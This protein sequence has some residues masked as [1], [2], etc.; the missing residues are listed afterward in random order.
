MRSIE[1]SYCV[2][3][4]PFANV[5]DTPDS[6]PWVM[7]AVAMVVAMAAVLLAAAATTR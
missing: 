4:P 1:R 7:I 5:R 2:P 6:T 3:S